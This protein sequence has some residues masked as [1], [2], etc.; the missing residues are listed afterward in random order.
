MG[1][2][3]ICSLFHMLVLESWYTKVWKKYLTVFAIMR[4][5]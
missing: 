5:V 4:L 3:M 2:N 1:K